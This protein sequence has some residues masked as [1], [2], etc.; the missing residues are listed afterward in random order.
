LGHYLLE[1]CA[2]IDAV[3]VP[4]R[5]D[6]IPIHLPDIGFRGWGSKGIRV[7]VRGLGFRGQGLRFMG[8]GGEV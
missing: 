6:A 8:L 2:T 1:P 3:P 4:T 7:R 5:H